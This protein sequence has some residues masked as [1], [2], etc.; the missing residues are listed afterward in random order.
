MRRPLA[1]LL[2]QVIG[3]AG[4]KPR[5]VRAWGELALLLG[6]DWLQESGG[7]P[8][9]VLPLDVVACGTARLGANP[10]KQLGPAP[11]GGICAGCGGFTSGKPAAPC[12][13]C[14]R[15]LTAVWETATCCGP[16]APA[17][18]WLVGGGRKLEVAPDAFRLGRDPRSDWVFTEPVVSGAHAVLRQT[19]AGCVI[20]DLDST[21][22]TFVNSVRVPPDG[23]ILQAGDQIML[24]P[25]GPSLRFETEP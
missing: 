25:G 20:Y 6:P 2:G 17:R 14:G 3:K 11:G 22:G 1:D 19:D 8:A 16:A 18:A 4:V 23:K 5:A 13:A 12:P 15:K 24:G 10:D 9:V 7:A 21:N